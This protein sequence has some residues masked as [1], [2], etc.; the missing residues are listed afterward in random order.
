MKTLRNLSS[1]QRA[2]LLLRASLATIFLYASI[3][4]FLQPREWVGYLPPLLTNHIS[5]FILL[6]FFSSFELALALAFIIG[7]YTRWAAVLAALTLAGIV[8]ANFSL[9]IIT[10]RDFA[11][12][13]AALALAV[14]PAKDTTSRY[15][16]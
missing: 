11:L 9:F 14:L 6:P 1:T 4:G 12:L 16:R 7:M 3:G 10:F 15:F 5:G 13:L 8:A 2:G